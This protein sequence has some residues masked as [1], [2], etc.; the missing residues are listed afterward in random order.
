MSNLQFI[1][2]FTLEVFI[3]V[4]ELINFIEKEDK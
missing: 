2:L 4:G 1:V 3:L